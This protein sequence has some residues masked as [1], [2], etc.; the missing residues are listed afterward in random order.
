MSTE[1]DRPSFGFAFACGAVLLAS[2]AVRLAASGCDLWF[3]E[4][5]T[6]DL[7]ANFD[8]ESGLLGP[9]HNNNHPLNTWILRGVGDVGRDF[10]V[11]R[12]HSLLAG[13]GSVVLAGWIGLRRGRLECLLAMFLIGSSYLLI[14]YSTEARGYSMMICFCL[15]AFLALQ[16]AL[17]RPSGG[18]VALFWAACVLGAL[19]HLFFVH[20]YLAA[21]LWSA[22][23]LLERERPLRA[24]GRGA[25]LHL[26][27]LAFLAFVAVSFIGQ[28]LYGAAV[29]TGAKGAA[30]IHAVS[31]ALGGPS[32]AGPTAIACTAAAALLLAWGLWQ[33]RGDSDREWIFYAAACSAALLFLTLDDPW[34]IYARY[35]LGSST[36]RLLLLAFALADL[37]RSGTRGGWIAGVALLLFS[38]GNGTHTLALLRYGHGQY[39]AALEYMAQ[40]KQGRVLTIGSDHPFR[41]GLLIDFYAPLLEDE[42]VRYLAEGSGPPE[43]F[44]VHHAGSLPGRGTEAFAYEG[45]QYDLERIFRTTD[46]AGFDWRIY[47]RAG[48]LPEPP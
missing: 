24:L 26:P 28:E 30:I 34:A 42:P 47:R 18:A 33:R 7:I 19:S 35:C 10:W 14:H 2:A 13:V 37:V 16:S 41:N 6:L 40:S 21:G 12:L 25:L 15:A 11:Y 8:G 3:D 29:P 48:T 45:R 1:A 27:V 32:N 44:I 38:F 20:F 9:L 5:W 43:F 23:V 46:L 22:V 36:F 17:E 39:L 4:I 31:V